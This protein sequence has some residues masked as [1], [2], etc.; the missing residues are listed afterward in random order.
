MLR[1]LLIRHGTNDSLGR[2]LYGR[3]PGVHLNQEGRA[4]AHTVAER[5]RERYRL[6]EIISSPL[7]RTFETADVIATVLGTPVATDDGL[8]EIDFGSW[9]GKS[10]EGL[11]TDENWQRYNESR[12]TAHPPGGESLT[13]VQTR[14]WQTCER[15]MRRFRS[16]ASATVAFVSHGDV[17]RSLLLLLLGMPLDFIHRLEIAPASVSEVELGGGYPRV[18]NVNQVF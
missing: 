4:Q 10:F 3:T 12:S 6:N 16:E 2:V 9:T 1:I 8:L 18:I 17:I 14:S 11:N 13:D 15:T 5:L 7:E